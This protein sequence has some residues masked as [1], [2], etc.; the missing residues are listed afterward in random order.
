MYKRQ[1]EDRIEGLEIGADDYL[2]KPFLPK[3]L[4]LRVQAIL[5]RTYPEPHLSLIH[6]YAAD[7]FLHHSI[8]SGAVKAP[9]LFINC[10]PVEHL[11]RVEREQFHY[12]KFY[13]GKFYG[14]AIS[15]DS[16]CG[17]VHNNVSKAP[18]TD[19]LLD[20]ALSAQV[21]LNTSSQLSQAERFQNIII[22]TGPQADVYK[23][24]WVRSVSHPRSSIRKRW[25]GSSFA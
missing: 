12:I 3:E 14:L 11:S 23:R 7:V 15:G 20:T 8:V 19:F 1:A 4:L 16:P 10:F 2:P 21:G 24:Q 22:P 18:Y 25:A 13:L 9:H 5:H 17:V 6:I